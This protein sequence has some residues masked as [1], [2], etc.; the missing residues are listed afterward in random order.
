MKKVH[1]AH[2]LLVTF[3]LLLDENRICREYPWSRVEVVTH[4]D[5][6][7]ILVLWWNTID[8]PLSYEVSVLLIQETHRQISYTHVDA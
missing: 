5:V 4:G 3:G 8:I 1:D 7:T 2:H 6:H